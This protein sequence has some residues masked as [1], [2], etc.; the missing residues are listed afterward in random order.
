MLVPYEHA[1]SIKY[2]ETRIIENENLNGPP[3]STV[4]STISVSNTLDD[5]Y[6]IWLNFYAK[7]RG[8]KL[9]IETVDLKSRTLNL[10]KNFTDEYFFETESNGIFKASKLVFES[11]P[12][13]SFPKTVTK[14][15]V[16]VNYRLNDA[17][18]TVLFVLDRYE[19]PAPI[20]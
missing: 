6:K 12:R 5:D 19:F 13:E 1:P 16:S 4:F 14:V 11:L 9:V 18:H 7:K 8:Q 15:D 10:S 2:F 17:S 20:H 3:G